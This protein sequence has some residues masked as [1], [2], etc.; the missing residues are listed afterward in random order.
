[1]TPRARR[2]S[3]ALAVAGLALAALAPVLR[4]GFVGYDDDLYIA[5]SPQI[6]Q[7]LSWDG[8]RWAFTS[9][10]GANWFPL[11]RLSWMLDAE[12]FGLDPRA[13]HATSLGLHAA[14]AA[15]LFLALE[16]LT[17]AAWPSA[18][19]AA[20]FAVHPL[21]VEPVAWAAYRRDV[22]AGLFFSLCLALHA[23]AARHG[24]GMRREL[25]TA[26][27][28]ALGLLAKPT[29]VTLPFVLCLLDLWPL[30]RLEAAQRAGVQRSAAL[31]HLAL[32]KLPLLALATAA[33]AV[34]V[35]AQTAGGAVQSLDVFPLP[36]RV[37]NALVSWLAYL[38]SYLY[39]SRLAPFYPHPGASLPAWRALACAALLAAATALVLRARRR[40]PWLAVGWLWYL[41][42]LVPVIG[43]VQVGAQ[44]RADRY[45]YLPQIGL[46]LA[47]AFE[48]AD[49]AA[50]RR[51]LRRAATALAL[52]WLLA[53]ALATSAQVRLW[54]DRTTLFEHALRVTGR[55]QVAH[56][57]LAEEGLAQGRLEAAARHA[58]AALRIAP[59][60][61]F[62][63]AV[64][65][66]VREAQGRPAEAAA[67]YL[68]ALA[69]EPARALWHAKR[70]SALRAAG[71]H[72]GALESFERAL[73]LDPQLAAARANYG[74][75]LL[76]AGRLDAAVAELEAAARLAPD[77]A[78]AHGFLGAALAQ[79]GELDLALAEL[80]TSLALDPA[81]PGV[82]ALREE[83]ERSRVGQ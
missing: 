76:E 78:Q 32:E 47:L 57:N 28:L 75:A 82:Q 7:G 51:W 12:L 67:L 41:G 11:T 15:L 16:A 49:R 17:G 20:L 44:A 22:L 33:S 38:A 56:V 64:L 27:A 48:L 66:G 8:L 10:Q 70:A 30:R 79:R 68:R 13:F 80:E 53:L 69:R 62:A 45:L 55:N 71:E 24:G 2:L 9:F 65:A 74:L 58:L 4:N 5:Q 40:R 37:A 6:A 50:G 81:Q 19:A 42:M 52:G 35:A 23:R 73:A 21:Q 43:L 60:E 72:Q 39:P 26:A 46:S 14:S 36:Q 77:L 31:A 29:L 18:F 59:G 34:T 1:V 63:S 3:L 61:P 25:P 54:R 83:L